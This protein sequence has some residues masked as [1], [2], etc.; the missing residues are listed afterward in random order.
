MNR[1]SVISISSISDDAKSVQGF[2]PSQIPKP[3]AI[4]ISKNDGK[5][6][7]DWLYVDQIL[8]KINVIDGGTLNTNE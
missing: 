5:I 6:D 1:G 4:V 7:I 2:Y 8:D 3:N